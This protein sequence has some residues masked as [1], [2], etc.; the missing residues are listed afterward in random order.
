M[1]IFDFLTGRDPNYDPVD[2]EFTRRMKA[3]A[4]NSAELKRIWDEREV[5][6]KGKVLKK[7]GYPDTP[8]NRKMADYLLDLNQKGW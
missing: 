6:R 7:K 4:D 5:W 2:K 8:E 3:N 1:G